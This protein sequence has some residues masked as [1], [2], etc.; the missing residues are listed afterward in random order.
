MLA[1]F[2][3]ASGI[4]AVALMSARQEAT[5]DDL[6]GRVTSVFRIAGTGVTALAALAGGLLAAAYG[7]TVPMY[8]AAAALALLATL[9]R[10]RR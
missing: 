2:G 9:I 8:A 3:A 7:L 5:P 6:M 1:L 4:G 10:L